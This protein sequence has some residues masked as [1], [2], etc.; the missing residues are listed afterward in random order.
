MAAIVFCMGS[1]LIFE[2]SFFPLY[3]EFRDRV[4]DIPQRS[5]VDVSYCYPISWNLLSHLGRDMDGF[6]NPNQRFILHSSMEV[7]KDRQS[8][9]NPGDRSPNYYPS[10]NESYNPNPVNGGEG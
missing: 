8:H 10:K 3:L 6:P 2:H 4:S 7:G 9:P 1:L 5:A